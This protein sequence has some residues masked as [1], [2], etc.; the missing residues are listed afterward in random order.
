MI[1]GTGN[2]I[3]TGGSGDDTM[4]GDAGRDTMSGGEG[5]DV[6]D[7]GAGN[8]IKTGGVGAD[9][10]VFRAGTDRITDF[11]GGDDDI[12]LSFLASVKSHS[13]AMAC[14]FQVGDD[15]HFR[16][17]EGTLIVEDS[18]RSGFDNDDFLF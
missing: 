3:L 9:R 17:A 7:G 16:F 18:R 11:V 10:F 2:D 12:D 15:V 5:N 6:L 13:Q 4:R 14:A 1:G 8:D